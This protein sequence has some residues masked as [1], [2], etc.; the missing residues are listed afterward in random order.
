M[1]WII[2]IS[3]DYKNDVLKF[4][5]LNICFI[6]NVNN[7]F[8][9]CCCAELKNHFTTFLYDINESFEKYGIIKGLNYFHDGS[10]YNGCINF[11]NYH[12]PYILCIKGMI[13]L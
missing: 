7:T 9:D 5:N 11:L 10:K 4:T 2:T 3:V 1:I 12:I 8:K 6:G 13:E